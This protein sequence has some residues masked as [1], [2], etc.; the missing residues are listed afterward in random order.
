[1]SSAAVFYVRAETSANPQPKSQDLQSAVF[2]GVFSL[3]FF[4]PL[5][6]GAVEPWAIFIMQTG[7]IFLFALWAI[8]QALAGKLRLI[9]SSAFWPMLGYFALIGIQLAFNR[10]S[11]QAAT[12]SS[13]LLYCTYGLLSFLLVQSLQ[14]RWQLKALL[15]GF[16]LYGSG[17]ATF[18]LIQA[19]ASNGRLYWIRVPNFGGWIYGS[20]VNHNHY[21]GLMELLTPFALA[22][23]LSPRVKQQH[24]ALAA[25]AAAIMASTIFLCGSRGGMVA[26]TVQIAV[27]AGIVMTR[28]TSRS[29]GIAIGG[30]LVVACALL[31]WLSTEQTVT[32]MTSIS[33]EMRSEIS[34]GTRL[35][36]DR[37][38]FR[39][40]LQKPFTGW[41]LGSFQ[42][43]YPRS[44]SFYTNLL[45]DHAHNDFL[46]ALVETGAIGFL[47]I[48][49]F[50]LSVY[51][52]G[53]RKL[54]RWPM[55]VESDLTLA[56]L[57]GVTGILVHSFVDFNL[58]IPANAALFFVLCAVLG[59]EPQARSQ[60]SHHRRR[61]SAGR[62]MVEMR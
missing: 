51:R 44:R 43:V 17:L 12:F 54:K 52:A 61:I 32:R 31:A 26:F 49:W 13:L 30:F 60:G 10:T 40:F 29:M 35:S 57:L 41:G 39:M 38:C 37:D 48:I 24:K 1:V 47:L 45:I 50:L 3:L 4:G 18:A 23:F 58:H 15:A 62:V 46:E 59:L 21:A 55:E 27:L 53:I 25:L 16:S 6:F 9:A 36:I 11:Y 2:F 22:I 42:E 5:A 34:G 8:Q 56:A 7:A 14:R 20:Y 19:I 28:Q 33:S